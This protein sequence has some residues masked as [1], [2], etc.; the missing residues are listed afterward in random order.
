MKPFDLAGAQTAVEGKGT[1]H[2]GVQPRGPC[3]RHRK[4]LALLVRGQ[5]ASHGRLHVAERLVLVSEA[6]P[7]LGSLENLPKNRDLAVNRLRG[8]AGVGASVLVR[9]DLRW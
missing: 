9:R 8:A 7:Q 1:G 4:Q 6:V 2:I 3:L 5:R